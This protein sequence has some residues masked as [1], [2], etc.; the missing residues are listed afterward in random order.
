MRVD[1]LRPLERP[2]PVDHPA[3]VGQARMATLR[4]RIRELVRGDDRGEER[5]DREIGNREAVAHQ[6]AAALELGDEALAG[7]LALA[8]STLDPL[9]VDAEVG[10]DLAARQGMDRA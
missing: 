4:L 3:Q 1:R 5:G 10:G 7:E 8:P 9:A 2:P 6:M